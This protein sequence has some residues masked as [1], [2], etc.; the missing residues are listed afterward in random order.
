MNIIRIKDELCEM[1]Y[2]IKQIISN[3]SLDRYTDSM[4]DLLNVLDN[5][6]IINE[7]LNKENF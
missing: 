2:L 6:E 5:I 4:F 1:T 7:E 3:I